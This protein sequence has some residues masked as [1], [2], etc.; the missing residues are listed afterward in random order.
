[1]Q[2]TNQVQCFVACVDQVHHPR[3]EPSYTSSNRP[4][5][6]AIDPELSPTELTNL[7]NH[8]IVWPKTKTQMT[9]VDIEP[10]LE[11][12]T[13]ILLSHPTQTQY[14]GQIQWK[15]DGLV[16]VPVGRLLNRELQIL[17]DKRAKDHY[18][19]NRTQQQI[20]VAFGKWALGKT[21][22]VPL[23]EAITRTNPHELIKEFCGWLP[24]PFGQVTLDE[25]KIATSQKKLL[26]TA[27]ASRCTRPNDNKFEVI[28]TAIKSQLR[29]TL[30]S[31]PAPLCEKLTIYIERAKDEDELDDPSQRKI[32]EIFHAKT[33][34]DS[35]TASL[36]PTK[37][38]TVT[39]HERILAEFQKADDLPG[40]SK[41]VV[42]SIVSR[43]WS[44]YICKPPCPRLTPNERRQLYEAVATRP[45]YAIFRH[46]CEAIYY[47]AW[48][49]LCA[50]GDEG[51]TL[52]EK[53]QIDQLYRM[54]CR[55]PNRKPLQ[56]ITFNEFTKQLVEYSAALPQ[57]LR[58]PMFDHDQ[59]SIFES[60][61]WSFPLHYDNERSLLQK[62]CIRD[63]ESAVAKEFSKRARMPQRV[64]RSL[65]LIPGNLDAE[66]TVALERAL[67]RQIWSIRG[68]PGTGKSQVIQQICAN[69]TSAQE[70]IVVVS[71]YHMPL[72]NLRSRGVLGCRTMSS[73][74]MSG[75]VESAKNRSPSKE[76]SR[77]Q[78]RRRSEAFCNSDGY[79]GADLPGDDEGFWDRNLIFVLEEAS[80]L[81]ITN[82]ARFFRMISN[83]EE[84]YGC[85]IGV[86]MVGDH[87]Q[88]DPIGPGRPYR[89][90]N[91]HFPELCSVLQ[92]VYRLARAD[93]QSA[94]GVP[95]AALVQN[96][97]GALDG[98]TN[99]KEDETFAHVGKTWQT[100][101]TS[102]MAQQNYKAARAQLTD[103]FADPV[104]SQGLDV[105]SDIIIAFK[106]DTARHINAI[107]SD[108]HR[109]GIRQQ[110]LQRKW[111]IGERVVC[112]KTSPR[113][114]VTCGLAGTIKEVRLISVPE[115]PGRT[116]DAKES[117]ND[118]SEVMG[119]VV[120]TK[121]Q[122][123]FEA[124]QKLWSAGY[125]VTGHKAQ[126][127]EYDQVFVV[128]DSSRCSRS[129]IYTSESRAKKRCF[130]LSSVNDY[131]KAMG[132]LREDVRQMLPVFLTL[133]H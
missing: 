25:S 86:V 118:K 98:E 44:P 89:A 26:M 6:F 33:E 58:P 82:L 8:V 83:A 91:D 84:T 129:W 20:N 128:V 109:T 45:E 35:E 56:P 97:L 27:A 23:Q 117:K 122:E 100:N 106:R 131:V 114:G 115:D 130:L 69:G 113:F 76:S 14:K 79:V 96:Y 87:N 88:L 73:L 77:G 37:T 17:R 38:R 81:K 95:K 21:D 24:S 94:E 52:I 85:R 13:P 19:T 53:S 9:W 22:S 12:S 125:A 66:Q 39:V 11:G 47:E 57:T 55:H 64:L 18:L 61:V 40:M 99:I 34:C 54:H 132:R 108:K 46:E 101:L 72:Q 119:L 107:I 49:M 32:N 63:A 29:A 127:S 50:A 3:T 28:L 16:I 90:F 116:A 68:C 36:T 121:D 31:V 59:D 48:R 133:D 112:D 124:P 7:S 111:F 30:P 4:F 43:P 123:V 2:D 93:N 92:R 120:E 126:G 74:L 103:I 1:M 78:K 104:V 42:D 67:D 5:D 62:Q 51:H 70:R 41:R 75:L 80:T 71:E 105:D 10:L 102:L 65:D 15:C 110:W 60:T